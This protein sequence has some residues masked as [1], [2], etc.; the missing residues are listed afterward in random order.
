MSIE[1]PM[2]IQE[3][4][5]FVAALNIVCSEPTYISVEKR[6][7]FSVYS[8]SFDKQPLFRTQ[9]IVETAQRCFSSLESKK[10]NTKERYGLLVHLRKGLRIYKKR[11]KPGFITQLLCGFYYERARHEI[12]KLRATIQ[13]E[14]EGASKQEKPILGEKAQEML[15][16]IAT[17]S[18][19]L[20]LVKDLENEKALA[21][22]S[23]KRAEEI[24]SLRERAVELSWHECFRV[25]KKLF[26]S[27]TEICTAIV[28]KK[29]ILETKQILRQITQ[30][31]NDVEAEFEKKL[32]AIN[33]DY[34]LHSLLWWIE[35]YPSGNVLPLRKNRFFQLTQRDSLSPEAVKVSQEIAACIER[36]E[37][38]EKSFHEKIDRR[39]DP[40]DFQQIMKAEEEQ[41]IQA[42]Q[43]GDKMLC[44]VIARLKQAIKENAPELFFALEKLPP[45]QETFEASV[46]KM[47]VCLHPDKHIDCPGAAKILFQI[48]D[49]IAAWIVENKYKK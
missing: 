44:S 47:K 37:T 11:L 35:C 6:S 40:L 43:L 3:C 4:R 45:D 46:K 12:S 25:V 19:K 24:L 41:L 39:N 14:L 49:K 48:L 36:A 2:P 13:G 31:L 32:A 38:L 29:A 27:E 5:S 22:F 1:C 33:G 30:E 28:Q 7:Q 23:K 18:S 26:S 21:N 17:L 15:Q 9:E 42:E 10:F 34:S 8:N 16:Q 20:A